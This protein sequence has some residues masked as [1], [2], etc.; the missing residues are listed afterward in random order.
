MNKPLLSLVICKI[1]WA[2]QTMLRELRQ[3]APFRDLQKRWL[4]L[5]LCAQTAGIRIVLRVLA[6]RAHEW[7][8]D[9]EDITTKI[10]HHEFSQAGGR[11]FGLLIID[12]A[13]LLNS[14]NKQRLIEL[15][16]MAHQAFVPI[17]FNQ[18]PEFSTDWFTTE[19][20]S[21][22]F[23]V[24]PELL[25]PQGEWIGAAYGCCAMLCTLYSECQWFYDADCLQTLCWELRPWVKRP[26]EKND[27][28]SRA[29]L[30][31]TPSVPANLQL[32]EQ[33]PYHAITCKAEKLMALLALTRFA[34]Y[35][36][37]ILRDTIGSDHTPSELVQRLANWLRQYC[38]QASSTTFS[39]FY[40]LANCEVLLCEPLDNRQFRCQIELTLNGLEYQPVSWIL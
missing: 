16:N 28:V 39:L 3:Q 24:A 13:S 20:S 8:V 35:L 15:S 29:S 33:Y 12:E 31:P 11:P 19:W 4:G 6:V 38:A 27:T 7:L 21:Y 23:T 30:S 2:L 9:T 32:E 25:A 18:P 40:P 10:L 37:I 36:K 26:A 1:E 34:H 14:N 5:H 17:L 22:L